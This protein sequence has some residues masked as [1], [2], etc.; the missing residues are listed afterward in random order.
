MTLTLTVETG[1][2]EDVVQALYRL[3]AAAFEPLRTRAAARHVFSSEE[4]AHEMGDAR[5]EKYVVWADD[6]TPAG[7]TT[8]AT[9]VAA[10]PWIS[11][12][13]YTHRFPEHAARGALCYLGFAMV[14]PAHERQGIHAMMMDTIY[15]RLSDLQAVCG[16]DLSQHS[17]DNRIGRVLQA[18]GKAPGVTVDH[19]DT[20]HYQAIVPGQDGTW[21]EESMDAQRF[22]TVT[23]TGAG[24]GSDAAEAYPQTPRPA[25]P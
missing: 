15:R 20:Q 3:Y 17:D 4:F 18:L 13:F 21:Q 11:P 7:L 1:L 22:Y 16:V 9:D 6:G 14:D 19:V 24:A 25:G 10:V 8:L 23:F 12:E 5:I 2:R